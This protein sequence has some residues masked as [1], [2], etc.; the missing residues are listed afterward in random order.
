MGGGREKQ[1]ERGAVGCRER[2]TETESD[3]KNRRKKIVERE[4]DDSSTKHK[5][6]VGF[7]KPLSEE[8]NGL[9]AKQQAYR[10]TVAEMILKLCTIRRGCRR[11]T[12][13]TDKFSRWKTA[14]T[15][16]TSQIPPA[17]CTASASSMAR[18]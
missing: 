2:Y 8:G 16:E 17:Y 3:K 13:V 18:E 9:S 4:M 15:R 12:A 6:H 7:A 11:S 10:E 1:R 5:N 14:R